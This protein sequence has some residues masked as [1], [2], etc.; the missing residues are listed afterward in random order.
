MPM[1][2]IPEIGA[3]NPY[4]K[5]GTISRQKI[6][7]IVLFVTENRLQKKSVSNC[8]SHAPETGNG[9]LVPVF[10]ADFW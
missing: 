5:P 3:Y 9:F 4:Q 2:H 1:T 8:M 7:S 10:G 6:E